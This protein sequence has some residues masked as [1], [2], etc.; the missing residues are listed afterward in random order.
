MGSSIKAGIDT[1]S[2][3]VII[4]ALLGIIISTRNQ[5]SKSA[6]KEAKIISSRKIVDIGKIEL[7]LKDFNNL[8]DMFE[9]S[10]KVRSEKLSNEEIIPDYNQGW[11]LFGNP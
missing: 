6:K 3:S 10:A 2:K 1:L 9:V 5:F 7:T 4:F 8:I 11:D